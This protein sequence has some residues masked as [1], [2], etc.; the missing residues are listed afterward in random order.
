[1]D[2]YDPCELRPVLIPSTRGSDPGWARNTRLSLRCGQEG[3][4]IPQDVRIALRSIVES[5]CIDEGHTPPIELEF[6]RELDLGRAG[7]QVHPD[8]QTRMTGK[9]DELG[10]RLSYEIPK[11]LDGSYRCLSAP[12]GSHNTVGAVKVTLE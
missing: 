2:V 6:V 4:D 7:P 12:S 11:K 3:S 1:M 5:W 9:V 10:H 8:P